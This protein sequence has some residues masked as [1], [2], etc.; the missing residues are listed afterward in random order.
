MSSF[1]FF[2]YVWPIVGTLL[3]CVFGLFLARRTRILYERGQTEAAQRQAASQTHGTT[4][5]PRPEPT[6]VDA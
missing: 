2:A 6:R 1:V 5:V 3:F 4:V